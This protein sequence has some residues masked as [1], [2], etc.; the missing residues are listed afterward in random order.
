VNLVKVCRI[1]GAG[2]FT[3]K[4][5]RAV[6]CGMECSSTLRKLEIQSYH[7]KHRDRL[8]TEGRE[9]LKAH[10]LG[11]TDVYVRRVLVAKFG[12]REFSSDEISTQR[13]RIVAWRLRAKMI[14]SA[15]SA[16]ASEIR[17]ALRKEAVKRYWRKNKTKIMERRHAPEN[18]SKYRAVQ[19][20]WRRKHLEKAKASSRRSSIARYNKVK[21][22]T[23]FRI[24]QRLRS[25]RNTDSLSDSYV[26]GLM[27]SDSQSLSAKDIPPA[28]VELKREQLKLARAVRELRQKPNDP[29]TN[30]TNGPT[31]GNLGRDEQAAQRSDDGSKP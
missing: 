20:R 11:L 5:T 21:D 9:Y 23:E 1:C 29:S 16:V 25:N 7:K 12:K 2:F 13:V 4:N 26:K 10:S 31:I 28:L 3:K 17:R 30:A 24:K 22:N 6:T 8:R 27:V 14:A 19:E 15:P 18:Y